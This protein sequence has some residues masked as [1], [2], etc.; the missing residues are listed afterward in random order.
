MDILPAID[1]REGKCVRLIQGQYDR[2]ITY[3]D[4]PV[5]QAM[6]FY[7]AGARW[8][9][10]VDLDGAKSGYS[11]NIETISRIVKETP[12]QVELGG[13]IRDEQTIG[14]MLHLGLKRV[15]LGTKAIEEFEWFSEMAYQ[16]SGRLV[17]GL[18]ARGLT[19]A[20]EGW[21]RQAGE[22]LIHFAQ[23]AAGLPVAAIIYTD[24]SKDGMMAGPN[25]ERTRQLVEAVS[26]PVIASGGV[27]TVEDVKRVKAIGAAGAIIGRSLY[28]GTIDLKEA[29]VAAV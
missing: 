20:K 21:L 26:I 1:L 14:Q 13:G 10:L 18:D 17:L 16:F 12:M 15:I 4:D 9:H 25:L 19:L 8:L 5:A 11:V 23:K 7:N 6:E 27:T 22:D 2:Q 29:L 28:E 24:I 3:K